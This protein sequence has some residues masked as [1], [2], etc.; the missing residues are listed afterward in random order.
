[1][2]TLRGPFESWCDV[3]GMIAEI[4]SQVRPAAR[5]RYR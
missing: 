5:G 2:L 1:M 3:P 4:I